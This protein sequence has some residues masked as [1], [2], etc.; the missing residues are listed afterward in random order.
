MLLFGVFQAG[1]HTQLVSVGSGLV[2]KPVNEREAMF[3]KQKS[4]LI[5]PFLPKFEGKFIHF[6]FIFSL[7]FLYVSKI[8]M[9][10][11]QRGHFPDKY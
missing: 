1:G 11:F 10:A 5:E 9:N 6:S 3:Y 8:E 7:F 2:S 4:K